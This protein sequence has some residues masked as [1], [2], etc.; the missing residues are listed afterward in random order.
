MSNF[1]SV[2]A[3]ILVYDSGLGG[4]STLCELQRTF[5]HEDFVYFADF[6]NSPYGN[7]GKRFILK[8]VNDNIRKLVGVWKPKAIVLACNT[9]TCVCV[10][11]LRKDYPNLSILG[12]EPAIKPAILSGE[13]NILVLA[14][15]TT[16]VH[17]GIVKLFSK[18]Q[19]SK[20]AFVKLDNLA[21]IVDKYYTQQQ[22]L[23]KKVERILCPF[24]AQ[25]DAVVLGCT[26]Y[27]LIKKH[28]LATLETAQSFDGNAGLSKRLLSLL[29]A[30][31]LKK[32]VGN[33]KVIFVS[34]LKSKEKLLKYVFFKQRESV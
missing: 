8:V 6:L 9:A 1:F 21:K 17:S 7:K 23:A 27:V 11:K 5:P 33:G 22:K 2:Y 30:L 24:K 4:I 32:E 34:S 10:Q 18:T 29:G 16:I 20:I 15:K 28:I 13:K 14:T 12:L 26:H 19:N 25:F 31:G 3:P